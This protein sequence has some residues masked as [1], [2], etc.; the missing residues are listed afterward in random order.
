MCSTRHSSLPSAVTTFSN[1]PIH[2]T[3]RHT[4]PILPSLLY[5]LPPLLMTGE[6]L[7]RV[8]LGLSRNPSVT[9]PELLLYLHATLQP[10]VL[11]AVRDKEHQKRVKGA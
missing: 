9:A 6:A 8:A 5:S 11:T 10:F 7:Q 1:Y 2:L 3:Y 4:Y